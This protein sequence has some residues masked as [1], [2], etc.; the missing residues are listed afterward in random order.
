MH[1]ES[2]SVNEQVIGET[3]IDIKQITNTYAWKNIYNMDET[4]LFLQL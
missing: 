4:G 2:G 3:I 1:G